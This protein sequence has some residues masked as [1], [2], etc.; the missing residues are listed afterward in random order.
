M[1]IAKIISVIAIVNSILLFTAA[2]LKAIKTQMD[3]NNPLFPKEFINNLLFQ[4]IIKV[5][6][7]LGILLFQIILFKKK[8]YILVILLL[9]LSFTIYSLGYFFQ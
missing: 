7:L 4:D 2:I 8:R 3:L 9:L 5:I 1:N 6:V